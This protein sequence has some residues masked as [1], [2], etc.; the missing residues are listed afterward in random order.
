VKK[1]S[2]LLVS[3]LALVAVACG[4]D[5][6]DGAGKCGQAAEILTECFG[7]GEGG[8]GAGSCSGQTEAIAQCI[9]DHP[10]AACL[11]EEA[12]DTEEYQECVE[13]ASK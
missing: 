4:D 9:I 8:E 3:A 1:L 2:L 6:D 10:D 12:T 7:E 11:D 5:D 13:N